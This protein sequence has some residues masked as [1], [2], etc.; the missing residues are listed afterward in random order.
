LS[1]ACVKS[2]ARQIL[3]ALDA[4]HSRRVMHRDVKP[5][6]LLIGADGRVK[7]ADFGLARTRTKT[8][9]TTSAAPL[10]T[11]TI[12]TR[13][14]RAP[15]ILYGARRYD[16]GVDVWSAGA[17]LGELLGTR[18]G[19]MLPG[20]SDVDQLVRTLTLLGTPT[21]D[22]WPGAFELPDY[23]KIAVKPREPAPREDAVGG[24]VDDGAG[25][26]LAFRLLSLDPKRRPSAGEALKDAYFVEGN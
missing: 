24:T 8:R 13:W 12:Q 26:A 23:G 1:V 14:Y 21:E 6:N 3:L 2:V 25:V 19:P 17:I 16:A 15:E 9:T 10:Y 18:V 7:L 22:R 11:H 20:D 5:G 4:C